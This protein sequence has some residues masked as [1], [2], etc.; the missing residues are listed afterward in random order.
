M[1]LFNSFLNFTGTLFWSVCVC[2]RACVCGVCVCVFGGGGGGAGVTLRWW[3][4]HSSRVY[5][6]TQVFNNIFTW[7]GGESHA[8]E[9]ALTS[10]VPKGTHLHLGMRAFWRRILIEAADGSVGVQ[11]LENI[12]IFLDLIHFVIKLN[13][14]FRLS[15]CR[16]ELIFRNIYAWHA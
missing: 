15:E 9:V 4:G 14:F 13:K 2:V 3:W 11:R 12:Y 6:L 7:G 5:G 1:K 8:F 10:I 16:I